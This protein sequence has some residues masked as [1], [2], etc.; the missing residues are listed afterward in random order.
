MEPD[1]EEEEE[2]NDE[3]TWTTYLHD[4]RIIG[5]EEENY[6]SSSSDD[7][8]ESFSSSTS[9][10]KS[11]SSTTTSTDDESLKSLTH[12]CL[13]H[14]ALSDSQLKF[15]DIYNFYPKPDDPG[16]REAFWIIYPHPKRYESNGVEKFY[17]LVAKL[18]LMPITSI[19]RQLTSKQIDLGHYCLDNDIVRVLCEALYDNETV[20]HLNLEVKSFFF[21][22]SH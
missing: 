15:L 10:K 14:V 2:E 22:V 1:E 21:F 3:I 6:A 5:S 18:G 16:T 8:T 11:I 19:E 9:T 13:K 17:D 4:D 7:E 20:K 12:P